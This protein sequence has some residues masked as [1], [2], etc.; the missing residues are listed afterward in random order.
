MDRTLKTI[1]WKAVEQYFTVV[2]FVFQFSP[3]CNF[4]KVINFGRGTI[5]SVTVKQEANLP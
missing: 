3:V 1:N 4:G 5:T 2:L